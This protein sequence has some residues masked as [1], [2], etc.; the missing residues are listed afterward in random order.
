MPYL[1]E[2]LAVL[3]MCVLYKCDA[4]AQNGNLGDTV[5]MDLD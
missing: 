5:V 4:V 3:R 2:G 1:S